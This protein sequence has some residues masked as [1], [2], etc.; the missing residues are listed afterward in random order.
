MKKLL[1][2]FAVLSLIGS[3]AAFGADEKKLKPGGCCDK[4]AKAG[5]KC[6]HKCCVEAEKK[7]E[8]CKKCNP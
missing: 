5:K 6:E 7:G 2:V 8:V 4:A 3:V 1:S